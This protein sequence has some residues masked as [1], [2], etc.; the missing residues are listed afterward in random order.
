[1]KNL[2]ADKICQTIE[3]KHLI[4]YNN[5]FLNTHLNTYFMWHDIVCAMIL[6]VTYDILC[7]MILHVT[8]YCMCH[9]ILYETHFMWHIICDILCDMILYMT[10]YCMWHD[11][12]CDTWHCM[13]HLIYISP[14]F[15]T[16]FFFSLSTPLYV[17]HNS[18][19]GTVKIPAAQTESIPLCR[20]HTLL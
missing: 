18:G 4:F 7:D 20:K 8:R 1:M 6:H 10:W 15:I 2:H 19:V 14:P 11:I 13:W 17:H 16:Y 12:V 5:N 9:I 3:T